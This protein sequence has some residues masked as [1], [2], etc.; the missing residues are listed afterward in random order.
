MAHSPVLMCGT[1]KRWC[2]V[3]RPQSWHWCQAEAAHGP[4]SYTWDHMEVA[5]G[6]ILM[7]R[8]WKWFPILACEVGQ[9]Q[10]GVPEPLSWHAELDREHCGTNPGIQAQFWCVGSNPACG[11]ASHHSFG[12][13]GQTVE[14][15]CCGATEWPYFWVWCLWRRMDI[16]FSSSLKGAPNIPIISL[17]RITHLCQTS[18]M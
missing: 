15:Y 13:W 12:P 16:H 8:A 1:W 11:W 18:F 9:R 10:N 4:N 14:H 2:G 5:Q 6:P 7:C 3:L 17:T